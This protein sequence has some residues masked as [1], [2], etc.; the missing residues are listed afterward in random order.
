LAPAF[1][2]CDG[3]RIVWSDESLFDSWRF[4]EG[5]FW[6]R[7]VCGMNLLQGAPAR[8]AR[9]LPLPEVAA[10]GDM[11]YVVCSRNPSGALSVA[12]LPRVVRE[13]TVT[14]PADVRIDTALAPGAP[15]AVFGT[16]Q[17]VTLRRDAKCGGIFAQDLVGG[18]IHDITEAS[19]IAD[20]SLT[21]PGD[22]LA[23]IG[24]ES[25]DDDSMPGTLVWT[26][27]SVGPLD[28]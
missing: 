20:G 22:L 23:R 24:S 3:F 17:S 13:K 1:A 16:V 4:E 11:P 26:D 14:P 6:Y 15:L 19:V 9:G 28:R 10:K 18:A 21:L 5:E 8:V 2:P 27:S 12:A 7:L 25:N